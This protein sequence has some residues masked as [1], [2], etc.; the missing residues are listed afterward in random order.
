MQPT[1]YCECGCGGQT[2]PGR[3]FIHPHA[4]K[5]NL[6]RWIEANPGGNSINQ[7]ID[8]NRPE[9]K[10][11]TCQTVKPR[12][13]FYASRSSRDGMHN[14]CK[15]CMKQWQRDYRAREGRF[16][17]H[18]ITRADYERMDAEQNGLCAIC[19]RRPHAQIDHCHKTGKVRGLLCPGCNTALGKFGDNAAALRRAL[20]Y[21][22]RA[23]IQQLALTV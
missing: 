1:G 21:L 2:K 13:E 6:R 3:R 18:G 14:V 20:D 17:R 19:Q 16:R 11:S 10:C 23:E 15:P 4:G 7:R 9:R 22:E 5:V 12:S 8:R